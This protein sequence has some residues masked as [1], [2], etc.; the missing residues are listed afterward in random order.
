MRTF[1]IVAFV[2]VMG[3]GTSGAK[4]V[5]SA[6]P[7]RAEPV[8]GKPDEVAA[9]I[10]TEA[11]AVPVVYSSMTN[12]A[13]RGAWRGYEIRGVLSLDAAYPPTPERARLRAVASTRCGSRIAASSWAVLLGFPNAQT[14][15][16]S[17]STAFFVHVRGAW[18]FWFHLP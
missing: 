2:G 10:Q 5:A 4:G 18:R 12:Q 14:I 3:I 17:A 13:G 16:A 15:P 8:S 7:S 9:L 1:V 11:R 6:C